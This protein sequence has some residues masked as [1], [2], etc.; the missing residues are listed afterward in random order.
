MHPSAITQLSIEFAYVAS[1]RQ[2]VYQSSKPRCLPTQVRLQIS[3]PRLDGQHG[4]RKHID[5]LLST[6]C[7]DVG[8]LFYQNC[9]GI[10]SGRARNV[11]WTHANFVENLCQTSFDILSWKLCVSCTY[12]CE[13]RCKVA[14][15]P[16]DN[17]RRH[18]SGQAPTATVRQLLTKHRVI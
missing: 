8:V 17:H 4:A 12:F 1:R 16:C 13:L 7:V 6:S 14:S 15:T 3:P 9:C 18:M 11:A 5:K 10:S 2:P